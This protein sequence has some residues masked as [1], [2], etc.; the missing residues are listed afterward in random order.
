MKLQQVP[1]INVSSH[2]A[3]ISCACLSRTLMADLV[4]CFSPKHVWSSTGQCAAHRHS[5]HF[6]YLSPCL[7]LQWPLEVVRLQGPAAFSVCSTCTCVFLCLSCSWYKC[8]SSK[9][10]TLFAL[11]MAVST[12][13]VSKETDCLTLCGQ[14]QR[15]GARHTAFRWSAHAG[16]LSIVEDLPFYHACFVLQGLNENL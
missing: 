13:P 5:S 7:F 9:Q 1:S 10:S 3:L 4:S 15:H 2:P 11:S 14:H 12:R 8:W 16:F 6:F